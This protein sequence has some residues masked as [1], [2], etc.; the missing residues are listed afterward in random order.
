[1]STT[2]QTATLVR[3]YAT[4]ELGGKY[5][6][7]LAYAHGEQ[8]AAA[9]YGVFPLKLSIDG[10]VYL[11]SQSGDTMTHPNHRGKGLFV[12]LARHTYELAQAEGIE[13]VFGFPNPA[14]YPGFIKNLGWAKAYDMVAI[15]I[16]TPTLPVALLARKFASVAAIQRKLLYACLHAFFARGPAKADS[17][18]SVTLSGAAG[19][20][21]DAPFLAYKAA[22]CLVLRLGQASLLVKYDGD[23]SIGDLID[24]GNGSDARRALRRLRLIGALIGMPRIRSYASPGSALHTALDA[25]GFSKTSLAYGYRDFSTG[26]DLSKLQFTYADY[27]TF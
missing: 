22:N 21:R 18:S 15:N 24:T 27:D 26:R 9:Y 14:S 20:C 17:L 13:C 23:I 12:K 19:V 6:G 11:G 25:S 3:K 5:I 10:K 2:T 7:Y 1:M 16:F 4:S 8:A